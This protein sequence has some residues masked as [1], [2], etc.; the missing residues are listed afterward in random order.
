MGSRFLPKPCFRGQ[1][2]PLLSASFQ[3]M[4]QCKL[5]SACSPT[6]FQQNQCF[7]LC[8]YSHLTGAQGQAGVPKAEPGLQMGVGE[9]PCVPEEG[10]V[11]AK[12]CR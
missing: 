11:S 5:S 8:V 1:P 3:H 6:E 12:C 2:V 9:Q 10:G 4:S 7:L